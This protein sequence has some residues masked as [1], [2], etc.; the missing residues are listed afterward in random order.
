MTAS[1]PLDQ[2]G[3]WLREMLATGPSPTAVLA[4]HFAIFSAGGLATDLLTGTDAPGGAGAM[5]D[6]TRLTWEAGCHA[7]ATHPGPAASLVV[8]VDDLQFVRPGLS[9]R[10]TAERL[11]ASLASDYL[12]ATTELP[13]YHADCFAAHGLALR[14]LHRQSPDR[15]MYSERALRAAAV[16]RFTQPAAPSVGITFHNRRQ[17]NDRVMVDVP[18]QGEYCLVHSGHTSC[19]GGYLEL[20]AQLSEAGFRRIIAMVPMRCLG[21]VTLGTL[22]ARQ[23]V[24]LGEFEV[25]TVAVPDPATG[26]AAAVLSD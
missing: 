17:S 20:L 4:G 19:A 6:F 8:L 13:A 1:V 23:L 10:A 24:R 25:I 26:N 11:A 22:L 14:H 5:L 21:Q 3:G 18:G 7:V 12:A 16:R 9:D 15:T 2:L